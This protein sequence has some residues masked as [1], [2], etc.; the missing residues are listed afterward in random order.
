M[1]ESE[2]RLVLT[3]LL[4]RASLPKDEPD[5]EP[6]RLEPDEAAASVLAEV[7]AMLREAQD[8]IGPAASAA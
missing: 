6:L 7:T 5:W 1:A 8:V 2:A 4:Q 3:H